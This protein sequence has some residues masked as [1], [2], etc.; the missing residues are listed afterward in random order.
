MPTTPIYGWPTPVSGDPPDV[1]QDMQDLAEAIETDVAAQAADITQLQT[2]VA[3]GW[4]AIGS[5]SETSNFAVD[6]TAGGT[7][8]ALT[9]SAIRIHLRG[10]LDTD[11]YL[12]MRVNNDSTAD[13]HRRSWILWAASSGNVVD[14]GAGEA[15]SWRAGMFSQNGGCNAIVTIFSTDEDRQLSYQSD[16]F[17]P[18]VGTTIRQMFKGGGDLASSRTLSNLQFF[19]ASGSIAEIQWWAEGLRTP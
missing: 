7:Y 9:F 10:S 18:A 11:A 19:P 5:G 13:M 12:N 2:D 14:S 4:T 6:I 8:P 1:P 17:R 15:T 16:G 3:L